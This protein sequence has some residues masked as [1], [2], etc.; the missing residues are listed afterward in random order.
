MCCTIA[1]LSGVDPN[2]KRIVGIGSRGHE[3]GGGDGTESEQIENV[4][5]RK[6][7]PGELKFNRPYILHVEGNRE[8]EV[9][10]EMSIDEF[11]SSNPGK[12]IVAVVMLRK[13]GA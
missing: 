3:R 2:G 12:F 13:R 7:L 10:R 1:V 11:A 9:R 6:T 4:V 8:F 5:A